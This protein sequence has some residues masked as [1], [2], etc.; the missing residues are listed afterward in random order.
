M[1]AEGRGPTCG[2][3]PVSV[4]SPLLQD[5]VGDP[6]E[7][8]IVKF[9]Y[10]LLQFPPFRLSLGQNNVRLT[11]SQ[12]NKNPSTKTHL[13]SS[14]RSRCSCSTCLKCFVHFWNTESS[15]GMSFCSFRWSWDTCSGGITPVRLTYNLLNELLASS[16]K[17]DPLLPVP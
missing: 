10:N 4:V 17:I 14:P 8:T 13:I 1:T 2:V 7:D 6:E 11:G 15:M 12:Y 5:I 16:V 3:V 9:F